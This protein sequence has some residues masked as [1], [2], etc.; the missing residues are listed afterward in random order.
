MKKILLLNLCLLLLSI[1]QLY[2]Q[3]RT[4]TGVVTSKDDGQPLPGVSVKLKGSQ[5]ATQTG[6]NGKYKLNN[7][8]S[9]QAVL[10]LCML[11]LQLNHLM[12]HLT[13]F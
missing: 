13:E 7:V 9:G 4:V 3:S 11:A 10:T 12:Y 5:I 6:P 8:P 2:A 1:S